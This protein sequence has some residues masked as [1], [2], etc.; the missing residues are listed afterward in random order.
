M[1]RFPIYLILLFV[2]LP[3]SGQNVKKTGKK[4]WGTIIGIGETEITLNRAP[5][6]ELG[7]KNIAI[8]PEGRGQSEELADAVGS[9]VSGQGS[10]NVLSRDQGQMK[11]L[12]E[13]K[14]FTNSG[15]VVPKDALQ[16]GRMQGVSTML[17]VKFYRMR[18]GKSQEQPLSLI[19]GKYYVRT[20][21]MYIKV[22]VKAV[23]LTTGQVR[24][25]KIVEVTSSNSNDSVESWPAYP[26]EGEL[27]DEAITTAA[28]KIANIFLP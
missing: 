26:P 11:K 10:I 23:D 7:L 5:E 22:S 28:E 8:I 1:K 16:W 3:T 24:Y 14:A 9:F 18:S 6:I 4:L 20:T 13:E 12:F 17:F 25:S 15:N 27:R 2:V 19:G 21:T